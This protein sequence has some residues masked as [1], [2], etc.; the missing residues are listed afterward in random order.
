MIGVIKINPNDI[1]IPER[2]R[3]DLG[4]INELAEQIKAAGQIQPIIIDDR[5]TLIAGLRR[6]KACIG[7]N[8]DVLAIKASDLGLDS[9]TNAGRKKI[10]LIENIGRKQF[11]WK[12]KVIAIDAFHREMINLKGRRRS[13][14]G[15]G[16]GWAFE[17][18]AKVLGLKSHSSISE[19]IK[20]AA[21]LKDQP[22]SFKKLKNEYAARKLIKKIEG[23]GIQNSPVSLFDKCNILRKKTSVFHN[24]NVLKLQTFKDEAE[25]ENFIYSNKN[26]I[27]GEKCY[28]ENIK[29]KL[30]SGIYSTIPDGFLLDLSEDTPRL[31]LVEIEISKHSIEHISG[32]IVK[33]NSLID[34]FI[35]LS[36]F[37]EI[38]L[39]QWKPEIV[40]TIN[41][42]NAH[43][44]CGILIILDEEDIKIESLLRA[45][46]ETLTNYKIIAIESYIN[47]QHD[48]IIIKN[49]FYL[50]I[51]DRM[52]DLDMIPD[53]DLDGIDLD[54]L[55]F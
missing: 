38:L 5:L 33:F 49:E 25:F 14:P 35:N 7:L 16:T 19:A 4:D 30:S 39:K 27:F 40:G 36:I 48:N 29:T 23:A 22:E 53:L 37:I 45:K 21:Y 46:P 26:I 9:A 12:E 2:I 1:I 20:L 31:Y 47:Q 28:F 18:T 11:N 3:Q 8:I 54:E 13:G 32:H 24:I 41:Q 44:K 6:L 51:V 34:N 17:D 42:A 43:D 50:P 15:L 55:D 10:E 52:A